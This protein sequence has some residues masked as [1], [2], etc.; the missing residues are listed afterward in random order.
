MTN[1]R[2]AVIVDAVRTAMC[3]I[4]HSSVVPLGTSGCRAP[5][6]STPVTFPDNR[7]TL[8]LEERPQGL[9]L[10]AFQPGRLLVGRA[11]SLGGCPGDR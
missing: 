8:I 1:M 4:N 2:K 5:R 6:S 11:S 10:V 7:I 3:F 9:L